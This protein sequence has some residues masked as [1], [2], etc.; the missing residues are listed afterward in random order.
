MM[1]HLTILVLSGVLGTLVLAGNAEACHK[2]KCGH[3]QVACAPTLVVTQTTYC[4]RPVKV[5]EVRR[6]GSLRG[7]L[8]QEAGCHR[9]LCDAGHLCV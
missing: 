1:R 4:A 3:A 6:W 9:G 5:Q 2:S 8:P 7:A